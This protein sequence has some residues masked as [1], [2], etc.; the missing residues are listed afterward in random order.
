MLN[1]LRSETTRNYSFMP[2]RLAKGT[3][4]IPIVMHCFSKELKMISLKTKLKITQNSWRSKKKHPNFSQ[5]L[6]ESIPENLTNKI[7]GTLFQSVCQKSV[8]YTRIP[9]IEK[10][11]GTELNAWHWGSMWHGLRYLYSML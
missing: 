1:F 3:K 9:T 8:V 2:V 11:Y 5:C 4:V 10:E 7:N 6:R